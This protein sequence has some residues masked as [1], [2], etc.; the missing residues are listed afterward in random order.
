[1][2]INI[3]SA[4]ILM[5]F[6]AT[7]RVGA[8][9]V[10][11]PLFNLGGVP[12][13]FRVLFVLALTLA[14]VSAVAVPAVPI[15]DLGHLALAATSELVIGMA[16]A[17]GVFVTFATF[18]LA[19]RIMDLQL[20]FGVANLIDP[21]TRTQVPL[22]GA[23][24]NVL[25]VMVF[26]AIDGHH[27]LIRGLAFSFAQIPPGSP[28]TGIDPSVLVAGFGGMFIYAAALAAPVMVI[29]LLLDVVMAVI[30]RTMPQVNVFIV[31]LPLKIFI[32]LVVLAISLNTMSPVFARIFESLFE[33]WHQLLVK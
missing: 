12:A 15:R 27:M 24:L 2:N 25:A 20:G 11:S 9:L 28:P 1:M 3:E 7:I 8:V 21:S 13:N 26:F 30:A 22:L 10:M 17:F 14:M 29:L 33:G 23:F 4:W 31:S 18:Q 19:G 32:G 6:L 16:L 5:L